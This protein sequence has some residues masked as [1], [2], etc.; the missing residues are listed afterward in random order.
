MPSIIIHFS[1]RETIYDKLLEKSNELDLTPGQLVKRF[2]TEGMAEYE[3]SGP[4]KPGENL[5]DFFV[6]NGVLKPR[7]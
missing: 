3:P 4:A 1:E 5:E 7:E 2:V 6:K